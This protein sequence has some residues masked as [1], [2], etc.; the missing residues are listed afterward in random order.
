MKKVLVLFV[1]T[2]DHNALEYFINS[3]EQLY[4]DEYSEWAEAWEQTYVTDYFTHYN[5]L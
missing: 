5:S 1:S 4:P 2:A 3:L